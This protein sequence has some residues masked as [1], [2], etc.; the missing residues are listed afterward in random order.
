MKEVLL[1]FGLLNAIIFD[2][3]LIGFLTL[4]NKSDNGFQNHLDW[5]VS[6][7]KFIATC[8]HKIQRHQKDGLLHDIWCLNTMHFLNVLLCSF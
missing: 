3:T 6:F 8:H 7:K 4:I 2:K 1:L 5:V